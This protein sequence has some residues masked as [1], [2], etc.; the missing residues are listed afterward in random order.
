[1]KKRILYVEDDRN[2]G[3]LLKSF[4]EESGFSV[5]HFD[6]GLIALQHFTPNNFDICLLDVML[7]GIDGFELAEKI[8]QLSQS[9]PLIL[10]T[11]RSQKNDKQ[12]GFDL[13]IDDYITKP[14]DEDELVWKINA[15]LRRTNPT[16]SQIKDCI[17]TL[18]NYSFDYNNLLLSNPNT[19]RRLTQKEA[20]V[21]CFLCQHINQIAKK[22]DVLNKIW[23]SDDYFNGRSL[24]VFITRIRKYLSL[25]ASIK[26]ETLA[27]VGFILK[28]QNN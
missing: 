11:A 26:I 20:D 7:P 2:M 10:I 28:T 6:N 4:L 18:G 12:H 24:D 23:G 17:L 9:I 21:L 22:E 25:D 16:D 27:K 5:T 14:F 3:F 8:R 19:S 15:L 13:K 1:M